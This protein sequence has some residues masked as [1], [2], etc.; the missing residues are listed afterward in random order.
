MAE[1]QLGKVKVQ[2][3]TTGSAGRPMIIVKGKLHRPG[4]PPLLMNQ[5]IYYC[6]E[7]AS[8]YCWHPANPDGKLVAVFDLAGLQIKNLDAAALRASFTMLEQHFPERVV[9]IWML[10]APTIF[11][12][13]WKLVSPF[14]DQTTRK[15]IHFVYGAAAREQ[16]VKSLGTDILPVEYG[17]SAAETPVEQAVQQLAAWRKQMGLEQAQPQEELAQEGAASLRVSRSSPTLAQAQ[18]SC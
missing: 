18:G 15:R 4:T 10:E 16:L 7:A 12:G 8:H 13:I 6:L 11:W 9:E 1:L 14:I 5:F 17:G 2:L 3:P